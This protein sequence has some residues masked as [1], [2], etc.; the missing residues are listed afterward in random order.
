MLVEL[1]RAQEGGYT[2]NALREH[3]GLALPTGKTQS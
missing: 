1:T 3:L 2:K